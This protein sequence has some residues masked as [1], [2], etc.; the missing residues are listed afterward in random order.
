MAITDEVK[1]DDKGLVPAVVQ[2]A[3]TGD[4]LMVAYMNREAL[5]KTLETGFAHFWSRSRQ[6][7]WKKGATSGHLQRVQSVKV[8]CDVDT[9]LLQVIQEGAA[10][11][12][13][14]RSCFY[15]TVEDGSLRINSERVFDPKKVYGQ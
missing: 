4:V 8:D 3:D 15:R 14:Y 2:D 9:I 5:E 12:E 6:E 7:L 10:C 1:F 11:H 13:G